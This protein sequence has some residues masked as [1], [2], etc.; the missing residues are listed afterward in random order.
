MF[1]SGSLVSNTP[2]TF[3][4]N[5]HQLLRTNPAYVMLTYP[6]GFDISFGGSLSA[7]STGTPL[8]DFYD[9]VL[10]AGP[11]PTPPSSDQITA[12]NPYIGQHKLSLEAGLFP[13]V[14]SVTGT[15]PPFPN[16]GAMTEWLVQAGTLQIRIDC[17]F[18]LTSANV[19]VK[20]HVDGSK[21]LVPIP[22]EDGKSDP[23]PAL[24]SFPMHNTV[25]LISTLE[26]RIWDLDTTP[27]ELQ[28]RWRPVLVFKDGS[29]AL[30]QQYDISLDPLFTPNPPSLSDG[31]D[32]TITLCQAVRILPPPPMMGFSPI[33]DLDA[34]AAMIFPVPDLNGVAYPPLPAQQT[35]YL[36][37]PFE[38][39][40]SGPTRWTDFSALLGGQGGNAVTAQGL[41]KAAIRGDEVKGPDSGLLGMCASAL[42]WDLRPPADKLQGVVVSKSPDGRMEWELRGAPP[43]ELVEDLGNYYPDLPM[44][45]VLG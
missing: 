32:P 17:G 7:N 38:T 37:A 39:D 44:V 20:E 33:V 36:S 18:A 15:A 11:V 34:T 31:A 42:G 9:M 43:A 2:G 3:I 1:I 10:K 6:S 14:P 40:K 26:L 27:N 22:R 23:I 28:S 30:W 29:K 41:N 24:F 45:T 13:S 4:F 35:D 25:G 8:P 21:D 12:N 5:V 16:T 19:V